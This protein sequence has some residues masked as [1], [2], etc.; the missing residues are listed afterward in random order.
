MPC[1]KKHQR[2]SPDNLASCCRR[3]HVMLCRQCASDIIVLSAAWVVIL[4]DSGKEKSGRTQWHYHI[5]QYI[6]M[7]PCIHHR[8][9][10]LSIRWFC[11]VILSFFRKPFVNV[12][13]SQFVPRIFLFI[14]SKL[15]RPHVLGPTDVNIREF[16]QPLFI[17]QFTSDPN[18]FLWLD[19]KVW[20]V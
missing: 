5:I 19:I 6:Q 7:L 11:S 16:Y 1:K 3:L 10:C 17:C 9:A 12:C 8:L 14:G 13:L 4:F 15:P 18:F 2:N 20:S